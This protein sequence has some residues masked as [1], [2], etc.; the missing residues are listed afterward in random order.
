LFSLID[1][2]SASRRYDRL[3]WRSGDFIRQVECAV[4]NFCNRPA[5]C[6][7]KFDFGMPRR[8]PNWL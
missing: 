7:C 8:H 2:I 1:E 5:R 4:L 3:M 6:V